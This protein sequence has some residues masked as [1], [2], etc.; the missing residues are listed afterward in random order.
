MLGVGRVLWAAR[1]LLT[2]ALTYV[3]PVDV[4]SLLTELLGV[5][6]FDQGFSICMV[7]LSVEV[8][9]ITLG[10]VQGGIRM[11]IAKTPRGFKASIVAGAIDGLSM[12]DLEAIIEKE[13]K[14]R[15]EKA[16]KANAKEG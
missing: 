4:K 8:A 16:A 11:L 15:Q 14:A 3:N 7:W 2:D 6:P 10:F 5:G 9:F 1:L 13:L 12:E